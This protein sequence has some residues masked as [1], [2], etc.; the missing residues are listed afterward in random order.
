MTAVLFN[1]SFASDEQR[2]SMLYEGVIC[3]YDGLPQARDFAAF[4]AEMIEQ[5]LAPHDPRAV[6]E[7]LSPAELAPLLGTLKPA[8]IHHPESRRLM[9][10][11]VEA[12][13]SDPDDTY[14]DVPRLRT[15]YPKGHL[16]KGIAY[17]F[18]AHR[19]T[20]YGA[21][22]AQLNWWLP[23]YPL[24]PDNVM[25]FYPRHFDQPV[26]NDSEHFNYYRRNVER[27]SVVDFIDEDPRVQPEATDLPRDE[28]EVRLLPNVG[29]VILFS[30]TQLHATVTAPSSMSRYSIDFRSVSRRDVEC[31][32]G[33]PNVDGRC[34]GTALRDFT[35]AH[36]EAPMPEEL[37]LAL[38][39]QGPR[40]GEMAVFQT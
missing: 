33:A 30:G 25:A 31:G 34:V 7:A 36:D 3:V 28:P 35:R 9:A 37:A 20:W 27:R 5:A 38:D 22:Q 2:R 11:L 10:A 6:H 4:A 8:F 12:L 17:A 14:L 40:E 24:E 15:A 29:G 13:G 26:G 32:A 23:V 39:P 1:R 18:G 21:P 19:D 16:T